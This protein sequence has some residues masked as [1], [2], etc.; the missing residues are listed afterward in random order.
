[1][2]KNDVS[3]KQNPKLKQRLLSGGK[4]ALYLEYYYGRTQEPRLDEN[5]Q[6]MHYPDGTKMAGR[7][8]YVVRHERKKEELRLY[9][10]AKPKTPED[11]EKNKETLNLAEKIRQEREQERLNDVMGYRVNTHKNDNIITFF[12]T[13]L[14]DYTKKDR[15]C[16][17]L[18]INRFKTFLREYRPS[19]VMKKSAHEIASI[20]KEWKE[21]HKGVY[22]KHKINENAYYRFSLKPGQLN[23]EMVRRFVEYLKANSVGQG[24]STAYER[25]KKVV[26]YA[27]VRGLLK[28]NPCAGI[29]CP[30]NDILTKDV[31][32]ADE[33]AKLVK[34]HYPGENPEIRRAFIMS[35]YTG[36]RFCDVKELTF[37]DVDYAN[38]MLSFEQSK[39][40]GHSKAS[41]VYMPLRSDLLQLIG[42]PEDWGKG[43]NDKI[44]D[45]PSHTMCLKALGHWTAKAGIQKHITWHCARHS[46]ATQV[47]NNG[48]NVKVVATLLGHSGLHY[49][50]KY[51]RALDESKA[52]AV[53]SLPQIG[54]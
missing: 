18:A 31:L 27:V 3:I 15:R 22:G 25:F 26:N 24:A 5:G 47:L 45:L 40:S 16:I 17:T 28:T 37:A 6:P 10:V 14:A 41:W 7:P 32:S 33:I 46:F 19:C 34:T 50:E 43:K 53:E 35:L 44:F 9:L 29:S 11:R 1:M 12:E 23:G 30:K 38:A 20:D 2:A 49:V 51:V 21:K 13:Y 52:R 36:I 39:T 42:K 4:I 54:L 8:M 48:A